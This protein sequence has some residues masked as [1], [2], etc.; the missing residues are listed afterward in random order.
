MKNLKKIKLRTID[1]EDIGI[2]ISFINHEDDFD[3]ARKNARLI[4]AAPEL[5]EALQWAMKHFCY[6]NRI[7][8]QNEEY[9]DA[10]DFA[11]AAIAKATKC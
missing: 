5:L 10:I 11:H 1:L 3:E 7:K 8:G 2:E 6:I 4:A 9:C